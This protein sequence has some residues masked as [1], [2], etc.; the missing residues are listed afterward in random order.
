MARA[1]A[2]DPEREMPPPSAAGRP[3]FLNGAFETWRDEISLAQGLLLQ[4]LLALARF[5]SSVIPALIL[6]FSPGL[7]R[8]RGLT[9]LGEAG[10]S[11]T[12]MSESWLGEVGLRG[13]ERSEA[14]L[15]GTEL[16]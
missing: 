10:L 9:K 3:A 6:R 4:S 7:L 16:S 13:A 15:S 12:E 8:R 5:S 1:C 2:I 14:E 11:G